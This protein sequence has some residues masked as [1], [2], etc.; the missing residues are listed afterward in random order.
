[1]ETKAHHFLIGSVALLIAVAGVILAIWLAR[2]SFEEMLPYRVYF[3]D[4]VTDLADNAAVRI[5]GVR[6]GS[7][8]EI[9][10]DPARQ[11]MAVVTIEVREDIVITEDATAT[12]ESEGLVGPAYVGISSG[13]VDA[14]PLRH[15]APEPPVIPYE[16]SSL[17]QLM[18]T[19]PEQVSEIASNIETISAEILQH[20]E[21]I[22]SLIVDAA[23]T[24]SSLDRASEEV[25]EITSAAG[26]AV[27]RAND[28]IAQLDKVLGERLE[29]IMANAEETTS[30]LA[31]AAGEAE[32]LIAETRGPL[33]QFAT[34]G[35]REMR[36]L[37]SET[38][39]MV[40]NLTSLVA[41][42]ERHPT[43]ILFGAPEPTFRPE[44]R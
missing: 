1:M 4:P 6:V 26:N 30:A 14:P 5:N 25:V 18:E 9:K 15:D 37:L 20:R 38:R 17:N 3:E 8:N 21:A 44:A 43:S 35:L 11:H 7:V 29:S 22:G 13:R 40:D 39:R 28:L 33:D 36:Q 10:L 19:L 41:Q 32:K 2:I 24:V 12:L 42:L 31:G 27:Q 23:S 16:R 34:Q